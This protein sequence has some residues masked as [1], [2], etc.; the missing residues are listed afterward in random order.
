MSKT[1]VSRRK[2]QVLSFFTGG[3]FLDL[4]FESA[5]YRVIWTNE[6]NPIFARMYGHGMTAW[7]RSTNPKARPAKISCLKPIQEVSAAEIL[8]RAFPKGRP[9]HFGVVGG[10]P[11]IDF[12]IAGK[13]IGARGRHGRLSKV[14]VDRICQLRP[15]FFVLENV[16][17]MAR[18][19]KH[20]AHLKRLENKLEAA[21]YRVDWRVLN[22]LELGVP[23]DR[24]RL[25][26][27]GIEAAI[28]DV[29]AGRDLKKGERDWFPWPR[30]EKYENAKQ[31][32]LWPGKVE[33][34]TEIV[35]PLGIPYELTVANALN[36]GISI[37]ELPN[38][39]EGFKAYSQKF[40]IVQEGDTNRRSFKRLHRYKYSPTAC[41]GHN[42]VHLHPWE[43][44]RLTVREAMRIQ[45]VPDS[46]VLP[47]DMH[48][49]A[50]FKL[51]SNGVP[52]PLAHAVAKSL[53]LFIGSRQARLS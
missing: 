33:N 41:Y 18:T 7:R 50:K 8:Q 15:T 40:K 9:N 23:Q 49:G 21:G 22:A 47:S 29:C 53:S 17:G 2:V 52:V 4:G 13:N 48:L 43:S 38:G 37:S 10:P 1:S 27:I 3:G 34:G 14:F 35:S 31:R 30:D 51:V 6:M 26:M 24:E 16:A 42:E 28:A 44:R 32:F 46:Y 11:C 36:G 19:K 25:V 20:R 12:S 5:G 39:K 45:G